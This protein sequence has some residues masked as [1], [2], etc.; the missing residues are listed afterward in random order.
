MNQSRPR[1]KSKGTGPPRAPTPPN[2]YKKKLD[3][4][5]EFTEVEELEPVPD[6]NE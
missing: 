2:P 1:N 5:F 4:E 3:P 6:F